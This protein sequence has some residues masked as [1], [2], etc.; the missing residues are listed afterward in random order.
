MIPATISA[1]A[2]QT[3]MLC[4]SRFEAE[5][6]NRGRGQ[7]IVAAKLGTTVHGALEM[8]VDLVYLQKTHERT[9]KLLLELYDI[10]WLKTFGSVMDKKSED[11]KD[12]ATMLKNWFERA[13]LEQPG[14]KVLS[15]EQ[16]L[17]FPV[18]IGGV[19][20]PFNYILDRFDTTEDNVYRVVDY[21][22]NR[23]GV[24][25]ADLR[26]KVQPRA[27]A[28]ATQIMYP[29]ASAIWVEFDMLRHDGPVG[30]MFTR[31]DNAETWRTF[32]KI[33]Q[34]IA[35]TPEGN[36]PETL[37]DQCNFCVRKGTCSALQKNLLVGGVVGMDPISLVDIRAR[38]EYQLKGVKSAIDEIDK[39]LIPN[40]KEEDWLS[41][42]SQ[43]NKI[44][45]GIRETRD[46]DP[47]R[48]E[49]VLGPDLW[50]KYGQA[51][52][53]MSTIDKLLKGDELTN[54]QKR[55]LRG[56]I[57][58]NQGNPRIAVKQKTDLSRP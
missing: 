25:P 31:D 57:F 43:S 7:D 12:G 55:D 5:N 34:R 50:A 38:L 14:R 23:W 33:F 51:K 58:K 44:E 15:V 56:L 37:N 54:E 13:D 53:L 10:S 8:F 30:A 4:M 9:L 46:I 21:K 49:L 24:N 39:I 26:E 45:I 36:A 22:T 16:K 6:L 20:V 11:Y 19:E 42:E 27:Y 28:L 40:A 1:T 41:L 29:D 3:A 17:N 32:K 2:L 47:T 18:K 35:D 52:I 48:A